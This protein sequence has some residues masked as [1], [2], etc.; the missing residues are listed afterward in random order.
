LPAQHADGAV[1]GVGLQEISRAVGRAVVRHDND[2]HARVQMEREVRADDVRVVAN[3][4][5]HGDLHEQPASGMD[6][7]LPTVLSVV[8]PRR[9][10][11]A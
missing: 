7:R 1:A 3:D 4:E 9:E 10:R 8:S 5:E 6:R 11:P 2:V